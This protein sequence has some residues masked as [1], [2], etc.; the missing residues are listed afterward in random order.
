MSSTPPDPCAVAELLHAINSRMQTVLGYADLLVEDLPDHRPE[1][2][3]ARE[4]VAGCE[5]VID[6]VR[7]LQETVR[8]PA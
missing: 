5:E 4:I 6:L 7:R 3:K 1:K 8:P 2:Q